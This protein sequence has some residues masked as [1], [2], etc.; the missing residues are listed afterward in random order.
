M[1]L[2]AM[3]EQRTQLMAAGSGSCTTGL[4][5]LLLLP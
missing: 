4:L 5:A 2:E 1:L 3:I